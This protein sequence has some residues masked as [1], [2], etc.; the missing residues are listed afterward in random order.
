MD[1]HSRLGDEEHFPDLAVCK[2]LSKQINH[3]VLAS[4]TTHLRVDRGDR[5]STR[6][7]AGVNRRANSQ[8]CDHVTP[9]RFFDHKI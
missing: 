5:W 4:V 8:A 1:F 9:T 3:L 6:T 7:P 2:A